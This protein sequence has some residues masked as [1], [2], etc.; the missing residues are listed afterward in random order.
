MAGSSSTTG[1]ATSN[2]E[3]SDMSLT[4]AESASHTDGARAGARR[5]YR[6]PTLRHLGSVRELTLG[7]TSGMPEGGGTFMPMM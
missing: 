5:P 6:S 2:G 3:G 1:S 7:S 4:D